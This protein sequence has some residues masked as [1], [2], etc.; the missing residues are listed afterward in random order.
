MP[1]K[2]AP[3]APPPAVEAPPPQEAV[4]CALCTKTV[5]DYDK[6]CAECIYG[7]FWKLHGTDTLTQDEIIVDVRRKQHYL[8]FVRRLPA[9][10]IHTRCA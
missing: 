3:P 2:A 7:Y 9:V 4:Q 5:T 1:N 8:C 6:L 10:R